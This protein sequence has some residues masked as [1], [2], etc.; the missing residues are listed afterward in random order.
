MAKRERCTLSA[1]FA[2][3]F[4]SS[5]CMFLIYGER[6]AAGPL[7]VM[8]PSI[9]TRLQPL[10]LC[11]ASLSSYRLSPWLLL[12]SSVVIVDLLSFLLPCV[13]FFLCKGTANGSR[14]GHIPIS[15]VKFLKFSGKA[16]L[17]R[18]TSGWCKI[19]TAFPCLYVPSFCL[20]PKHVKITKAPGASSLIQKINNYDNV[21][22]S[23]DEA[24]SKEQLEKERDGLED[25]L[26]KLLSTVWRISGNKL[27]LKKQEL[28]FIQQ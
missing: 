27:L 16:F 24:P 3:L 10:S 13:W 20:S 19:F 18:K 9:G 28:I 2:C 5:S 14:Q 12:M 23:G 4:V 26:R 8:S 21:Y 25:N 6:F 17:I 22:G 7:V 15:L 1:F 11:R